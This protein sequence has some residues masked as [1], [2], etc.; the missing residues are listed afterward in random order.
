MPT[1]TAAST[2]PADRAVRVA[3]DDLIAMRLRARALELAPARR[4]A[5][6]VSGIH[7]S[8]FRG[9]GVD[10]QESRSYQPGDDIRHMDW[11]VTARTG[12]PHTK[13]FQEERERSVL[14][15]LDHNPSMHFGTRVRFKSVQAARAAALLA[16]ATVQG[17]DRIGALSLGGGLQAECKPAGGPRG[18]LHVLRLLR[19][20]DAAATTASETLSSALTRARRL[21][22]PGSRVFL[23]SDGFCADA[24]AASPLA[25]LAA[26]CDF[27][28]VVLSD[29][30]EL[31]APPPGRYAVR[32]DDSEQVLDFSSAQLRQQWPQVFARRRA[33]LLALLKQRALPSVMLD[34]RGEPEREIKRLLAGASLSRIAI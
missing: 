34:T 12:R 26:H 24:A 14:L 23:F 27:A 13:L 17:G 33:E 16:W 2:A 9:R 5:V 3:L 30:L 10:Y 22:R 6:A 21:V 19:D 4:A 11:R 15:I 29:P 25:A 31:I 18:A 7:G 28:T 20:W 32:V 1:P 8:R